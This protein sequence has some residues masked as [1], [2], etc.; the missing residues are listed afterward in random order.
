[1]GKRTGRIL[2]L[3]HTG[4]I[5]DLLGR[6]IAKAVRVHNAAGTYRY[7]WHAHNYSSG[8]YFFAAKWNGKFAAVQKA[9][10]IK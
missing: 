10:L 5:Y 8:I 1:M 4:I 7:Q 2:A 6:T 9:V 3:E